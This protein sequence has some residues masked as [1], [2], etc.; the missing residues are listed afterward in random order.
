MPKAYELPEPG[1]PFDPEVFRLGSPCKRNHIHAD[2]MTLRWR[3][4]K[5]CPI[6]ER[7]DAKQRMAERRANDPDYNR[8]AAAYVAAKRKRDGREYRGKHSREWHLQRRLRTAI[9]RSG[10][11]P[12]VA[13]LVYRQQCAYWRAHPD[14]RAEYVR[15]RAR[16]YARFRHLTDISYRLYQRAK[17]RARHIRLR[18]PL[19]DQYPSPL[20]Q[21][22]PSQLLTRWHQFNHRCA[23]CNA[24]GEL[25]LEHVVPISK[26]GLHHIS[27]IVPA[28]HSCN[29]SKRAQ[30]A[31]QWFKRQTFYREGRW[32]RIQQVLNASAAPSQLCLDLAG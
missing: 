15:N 30:D 24:S 3:K 1:Q 10:R 28:C 31:H 9:N 19:P 26:G 21:P 16:D 25:E 7:I 23:Y 6:C 12:S 11:C 20:Q 14:A 17:T 32:A 18:S 29:S 5:I 22:T 27:N 8:K 13:L 4:R 2:G